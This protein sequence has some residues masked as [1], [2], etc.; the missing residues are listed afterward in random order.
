MPVLPVNDLVETL[1]LAAQQAK[2]LQERAAQARA[3]QG[4]PLPETTLASTATPAPKA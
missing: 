3:E 1:K 2:A 4:A